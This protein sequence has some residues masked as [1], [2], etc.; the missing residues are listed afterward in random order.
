MID[1]S[2]RLRELRASKSQRQKDLADV[3]GVAQTTIANYEQGARFPDEKILHRIADFFD[4]SLDYLLGRSDVSLL[5]HNLPYPNTLYS[6]EEALAPMSPLAREYLEL[7]LAG[8]REE[9]G[10]QLGESGPGCSGYLQ[11]GI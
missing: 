1:F 11:R 8:K 5:A 7:I 9:A 4:V 3:I 2:S 10:S 6:D